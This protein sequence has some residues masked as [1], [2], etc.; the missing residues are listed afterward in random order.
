MISHSYWFLNLMPIYY[1]NMQ[2]LLYIFS[3]WCLFLKCRMKLVQCRAEK[4]PVQVCVYLS[5]GYAFMTQ[6]FL[7]RTQ[8]CTA[9]YKMCSKGV[10]E[11][12]RRNIFYNTCL[13]CKV[14]KNIKDH[15]TA[16]PF[17]MFI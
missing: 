15:Y 14:F 2:L 7:H 9:F 8:V 17:A 16:K 1:S 6:H 13:F 5:S 3:T 11:G 12:M 10:P 4:I